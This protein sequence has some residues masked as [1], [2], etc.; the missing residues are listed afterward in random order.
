MTLETL[1]IHRL[2]I[3]NYSGDDRDDR[4]NNVTPVAEEPFEVMGRV[5][6]TAADEDLD[7]RA[8]TT[9]RNIVFVPAGTDI[10]PASRIAWLDRADDYILEVDGEPMP[11]YDAIGEHHLEVFA[12]RIRG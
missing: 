10:R 3:T 7:D 12:Y 11:T 8:Q 1:L 2:R 6:I 9:T 4:Y 5:D